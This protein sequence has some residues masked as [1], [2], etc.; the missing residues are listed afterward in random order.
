[1]RGWWLG[2]ALCAM[3]WTAQAQIGTWR[4]YTALQNVRDVARSGDT[5]W[6]ATGG[7]LFSW[8]LHSADFLRLTNADGLRAMDLT[9]VGVDPE[10]GVWA[11]CSNGILHIYT[12]STGGWT[13]LFDI[14]V[15]TYPDRRINR[16][17]AAGD[18]MLIC[19]EFGVSVFNR[20][21]NA[22]GDTY[23][24][25]SPLLANVRAGALSAAYFHDRLWAAVHTASSA[26]YIAS[27]GLSGSNLLPPEAWTLQTI[28][29]STNAIRSL[30][31]ASGRL[32]AG[33]ASG[34]YALEDSVWNAVTDLQ[35]HSIIAVAPL[36]DGLLVATA[37]PAVY[38]VDAQN[39]V[40]AYPASLPTT[41]TSL[42]A[43][44]G[45]S[46]VAGTTDAGLLTWEGAWTRHMPDGP[47]SNQFISVAVDPSGSVWGASGYV[48][49]GKGIYRF[50]GRSW[51][52]FTAAQD[53]LPTNDY[54][55]ISVGCN[56][57]MWAGSWGNGVVEI[58]AGADT[59]DPARIFGTN[60][61]MYGLGNDSNYV[62]VSTAVCDGAGNTWMSIIKGA[63]NSLVVLR[64]DRTWSFLPVYVGSSRLT[65]LV[66]EYPLDRSMTVDGSGNLWALARDPSF[67]GV[68]AFGNGGV[69]GDT[70]QRAQFFL[71][72]TS[73]LPSNEV[74]TIVTDREQDI[75]VGTDRGIA[76]ILDPESP[77]RSGAIAAYRPLNGVGVNCIAVDP[78]NQKWVGTSEGV[79]LLSPDG[80]QQLASFTVTSTGGK[81][82]DN[83]VKSIAVDPS[84]GT[85]YF[86]T[87][88]GLASLTTA[89]AAPRVSFG[90][91]LVYP[92]PYL[93][94]AELPLTVDGLV[95]N[96]LLKILSIDGRVIRTIVT[97]G[98]RV[99]YWDGKDEEGRT[100][101][102]G[103]YVLVASSEQGTDVATAKV[104]VIRR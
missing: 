51:R 1:M 55:R 30:T 89:A 79:V 7:G 48:G 56:G 87:A 67:R 98:G 91:L 78:L 84:T 39:T 23:T 43:T 68:I 62:V 60:V 101:A 10:G 66:D 77:T 61:G 2:A 97:P 20:R 36:A 18:T 64:P 8:R 11:G 80:T 26:Y 27:A 50:N 58:P 65:Y 44:E 34:L 25:F 85:V 94:P 19:T 93:V 96:S 103:V 22:F 32:Y 16:I 71:T 53:G 59:I 95:E 17:I 15:M 3:M 13:Y 6:A 37:D 73:G 49:N 14:S 24:K 102:S 52:S 92:N 90:T 4:N 46:A 54:Y 9:A 104:A 47:N 38:R 5:F 31:V 75:W 83:D 57:S 81:L 42:T 28:G 63:R 100:V 76:I 45:D 82:I 21:D 86:G 33:T 35:G 72:E 41:P 69:V 99:G 40:Q 74:R 88:N 12:P 70:A 29:T